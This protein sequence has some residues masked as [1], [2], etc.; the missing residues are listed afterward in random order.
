MRP[1]NYCFRLLSSE[2]ALFTS[3][4]NRNTNIHFQRPFFKRFFFMWTIFI[5]CIEFVTILLLF[6]VLV[7]WPWSKWDLSFLTRN[8]TQPPT[9]E[10]RVL[11]TGP[12]G[13]SLKQFSWWQ[14]QWQNIHE[15]IVVS[16]SYCYYAYHFLLKLYECRFSTQMC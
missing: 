12:P 4:D 6:Y 2:V 3:K 7:F 13:K 11:T 9:P 1:V 15:W 8:Q 14:S 16:S 5:V 10:C